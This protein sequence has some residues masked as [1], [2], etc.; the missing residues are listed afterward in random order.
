MLL[1]IQEHQYESRFVVADTRYDII[2]GTPW[3]RDVKPKTNYERGIVEIGEHVI[4]GNRVKDR[5]YRMT[6]IGMKP[7]KN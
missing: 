7:F 4:Q 3:H 1:E 2:L 6:N 5:A